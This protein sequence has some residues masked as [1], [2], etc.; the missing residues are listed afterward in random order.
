MLKGVAPMDEQTRRADY[1]APQDPIPALRA[2]RQM[3]RV[4]IPAEVAYDLGKMQESLANIARATGHPACTSG[5][6]LF[7]ELAREF[8]INPKT[9]EPEI[10]MG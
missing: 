8:V 2:T 3:I 5:R 9:L 10:R 6:D 4:T 1:A 7:F